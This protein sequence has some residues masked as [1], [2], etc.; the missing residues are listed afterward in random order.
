MKNKSRIPLMIF[1][2]LG[3]LGNIALTFITYAV[4]FIFVVILG[5]SNNE[6]AANGL[7]YVYV[8]LATGIILT[9]MLDIFV[10]IASFRKS[11][12]NKGMAIASFISLMVMTFFMTC[13]ALFYAFVGFRELYLALASTVE[14]YD[15]SLGQSIAVI[16][17]SI[18][19]LVYYCVTYISSGIAILKSQKEQE[20]K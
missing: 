5:L 7:T 10:L 18:V 13:V 16:V 9:I 20:L 11:K 12:P 2:I 6:N 17:G 1:N 8:Y 4:F 19:I 3:N 14:E 15:V